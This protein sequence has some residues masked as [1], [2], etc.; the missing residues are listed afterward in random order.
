MPKPDWLEPLEQAAHFAMDFGARLVFLDYLL[1]RREAVTQWPPGDP[2]WLYKEKFRGY[3]VVDT[4]HLG[5]VGYF[6]QDR[7]KDM[8]TDMRWYTIGG[9]VADVFRAGLVLWWMLV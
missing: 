1:W 3:V 7:V 5:A 4:N 9:T 6:P 2:L 8:M